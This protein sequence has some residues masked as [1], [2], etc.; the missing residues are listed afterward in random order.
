MNLA[1]A[2]VIFVLSH[3]S[4]FLLMFSGFEDQL[5]LWSLSMMLGPVEKV[6]IR[7]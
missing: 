5:C 1:S 4:S 3:I 6:A 7:S 2:R